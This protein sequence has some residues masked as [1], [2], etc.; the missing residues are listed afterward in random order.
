MYLEEFLDHLFYSAECENKLA[1]TAAHKCLRELCDILGPN[2]M[3][4]R[5]C[6]L[7]IL[8]GMRWNLNVK[9]YH[10]QP[11]TATVPHYLFIGW[12]TQPAIPGGF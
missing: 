4:G 9:L 12:A 10:I 7:C 8:V 3:R 5:V 11:Y 1:S 2:I 6:I